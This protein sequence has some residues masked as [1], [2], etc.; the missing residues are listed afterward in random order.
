MRRLK[1][2]A[3]AL[4]LLLVTINVFAGS[5][6]SGNLTQSEDPPVGHAPPLPS[7]IK[8]WEAWAKGYATVV[9][10]GGTAYIVTNNGPSDIL[11][12][13]RVMLLS[14]SPANPSEDIPNVDDETQDGILID[15]YNVLPGSSLRF[16]YGDNAIPPEW[17]CSE[18]TESTHEPTPITLGGEIPPYDLWPFV[19]N[20]DHNLA[21]YNGLPTTVTQ[22]GIWTYLRMNP[23][24]VIGKLPLWDEIANTVTSS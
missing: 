5:S 10:T 21:F 1:A 11:I 14:P 2:L 15:N 18:D 22:A 8:L 13:D 20:P 24:L 12:D 16:E 23:T 4:S 3:I 17:W 6:G 9:Q 19:D 7:Q